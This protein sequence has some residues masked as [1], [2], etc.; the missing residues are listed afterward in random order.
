LGVSVSAD[1]R[2]PKIAGACAVLTAFTTLAIHL[3]PGLW[4]D[5]GSFEE[6]IDLRTNPIYIGR[7][8]VVI[9]H[10]LLV[11]VSMHGVRAL[12]AGAGSSLLGLGF[13]AFVVFAYTEVLRT[14]LVIFALNRTWRAAYA[15]AADPSARDRARALI[16][17]FAGVNEALFFIFFIAFLLGTLCYGLA[18]RGAAGLTGGVGWLF[19]VWAALSLPTLFDTLTGTDALSPFFGW[20][21]P[22]FQAPARVLIGVWLWRSGR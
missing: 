14:S 11:V 12:V 10:C 19:L 2:L 1:A 3:L 5:V 7:L 18:L 17:G 8:F 16:E 6:Q 15:A 13:L 4:A 20:V 21:G 22:Y 9:V